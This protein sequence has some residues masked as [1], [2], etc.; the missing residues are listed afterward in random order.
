MDLEDLGV[1]QRDR[2]CPSRL[3]KRHSLKPKSIVFADVHIFLMK[4]KS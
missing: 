1:S 3:R 2:K 4:M